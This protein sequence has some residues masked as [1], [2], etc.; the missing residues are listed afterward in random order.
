[1]ETD[2]KKKKKFNS[3][4]G[5]QRVLKTVKTLGKSQMQSAR[6][7]HV[8]T[9]DVTLGSLACLVHL[10]VSKGLSKKIEGLLPVHMCTGQCGDTHTTNNTRTK[11]P[12]AQAEDIA[13]PK[14]PT[15]TPARGGWEKIAHNSHIPKRDLQILFYP[16][17]E[18]VDCPDKARHMEDV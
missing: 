11:A 17:I 4:L 13:C 8:I 3:S 12:V 6:C 14:A 1:M 16:A 7:T 9:T 15:R 2:C 18:D 5:E 10:I